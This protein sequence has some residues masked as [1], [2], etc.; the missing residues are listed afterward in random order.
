[1]NICASAALNGSLECLQ[2]LHLMGSPWDNSSTYN[3]GKRKHYDCLSYLIENKCTI[4]PKL[5]TDAI[6]KN[7]FE[8]LKYLH[9]DGYK[10]NTCLCSTAIQNKNIKI[11]KFLHESGYKLDTYQNYY[12]NLC[13]ISLQYK[14]LECLRY[15]YNNGTIWKMSDYINTEELYLEFIK[16][17]LK[18]N[19]IFEKNISE[20]LASRGY[21]TCLKYLLENDEYDFNEKQVFDITNIC[22]NAGKNGHYDLLKYAIDKKLYH[23][24]TKQN[25]RICQIMAINNELQSLKILKENEFKITEDIVP[26]T[27]FFGNLNCLKYIYETY[28]MDFDW[29]N[30]QYFLSKAKKSIDTEIEQLKSNK[31]PKNIIDKIAC[32]DFINEKINK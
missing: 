12:H 31:I 15:C 23:S 24:I 20:D 9:K 29:N 30:I 7:D 28:Q 17:T 26:S 32:I 5:A 18:N 25:G 4:S 14:D 19:R 22:E 2:Y 16:Y 8:F 21:L 3:A 13:T 10:F 27:I 11:L 6:N 1:V